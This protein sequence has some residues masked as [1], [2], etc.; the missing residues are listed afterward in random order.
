[1]RIKP[2]EE[3]CNVTAQVFT[4]LQSAP[5]VLVVAP[6][7][8]GKTVVMG[9]VARTEIANGGRVLV[10]VNLQVLLG[11]TVATM[12]HGFGV[13]TAALHEKM[14]TYLMNGVSHPLVCDYKRKMLVTLPLT[15]TNTIDAD[16]TNK[17]YFD[18]TFVPTMI[19]LDEAHK[20]TAAEFQKIRALWPEAKIVGFTATPYREKND[21]GE[22]LQEWYE[23]RIIIAATM[24][25]LI[26]RGNLARPRYFEVKGQH[27]AK[28]WLLATST[29]TNKRT[30][31]FTDDTNHSKLL[32]TQFKE[33]GISCEV[34]TSGKGVIG[35]ADYVPR[36]SPDVRDA[37]FARFYRGETDVLISVNALCE[38]FD[39]KLAKFCFLTRR[40]AN[41]AF[42]QQMV[43]RVLR[44]CEGKPEGFVYDF[45]DNLQEHGRV[46]AIEWPRAAKGLLLGAN[47]NEMC[48][49]SFA[50]RT[51][52]WKVCADAN[53]GHV[54]NIKK[55][56][57]CNLCG[58]KHLVKL[59][60]QVSNVARV[61]LNMDAKGFEAIYQTLESAL[62]NPLFQGVMNKKIGLVIF[63]GGE[64]REEYDILPELI[65]VYKLG[66][67][68]VG[69]K[70][71][72]NWEAQMEV[73]AAWASRL[74]MAA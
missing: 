41:I 1:M 70:Y 67:R 68:K 12:E 71:V 16:K 73:D 46:E 32:E 33:L 7:G 19:I 65:Q 61:M 69:N 50:K 8:Y 48:V 45:E 21:T 62:T 24:S 6:T 39:E 47:D 9:D 72:G 34:V 58:T 17:L 3:Q 20:A 35:D 18:P 59:M 25:E 5:S 10:V 36:Q 29:H 55:S 53:C 60:T 31:V 40:V 2:R 26:E 44:Q 43:G 49:K 38:G 57:S 63:E 30:I 56:A 4:T 66:R 37:I 51:N 74:Q 28:T 11:Q 23:D 54:Y 22:S 42:Y 64:L 27:V 13:E 52:V 14:T 15:L